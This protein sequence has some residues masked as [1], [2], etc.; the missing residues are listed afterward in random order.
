[1]SESTIDRVVAECLEQCRAGKVPWKTA[2]RV[3]D[4]LRRS[5]D[6]SDGEIIEL[7]AAVIGAL[8]EKPP[9]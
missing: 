7:Q 1:M 9:K 3:I 5:G 6:W 8:L 4:E 2:A